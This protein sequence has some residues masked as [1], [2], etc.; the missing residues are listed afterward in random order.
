MHSFQGQQEGVAQYAGHYKTYFL[1]GGVLSKR[2]RALTEELPTH[3]TQTEPL[4]SG[5]DR[6][7]Q[8]RGVT[9]KTL[10]GF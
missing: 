6:R 8:V 3:Q 2:I 9:I 1:Q 4:R 10:D 7:G 5:G